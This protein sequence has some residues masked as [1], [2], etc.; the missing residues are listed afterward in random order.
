M[1]SLNITIYASYSARFKDDC[2]Q[3]IGLFRTVRNNTRLMG[4]RSDEDSSVEIPGLKLGNEEQDSDDESSGKIP[5]LID[6]HDDSS[7]E[8]TVNFSVGS[9]EVTSDAENNCR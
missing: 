8:D 5:D 4:S 1:P 3:A 7:E 2:E 6:R 9:S